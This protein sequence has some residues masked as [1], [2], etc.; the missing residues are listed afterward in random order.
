MMKRLRGFS[1]IL[2]L[3]AGA[4][5]LTAATMISPALAGEAPPVVASIAPV[6]SLLAGVMKGAGT[7]RLLMKG[8]GSPHAYALKPSDARALAKARAV[9]WIGPALEGFL[10]KPLMGLTRTVFT[11]E[12]AGAEGVVT[13]R[14]GSGKEPDPHIWLDPANAA[15]MVKTMVI[16]LA[17]IDP[18]NAVLY[19][20]NGSGLLAGL[21]A[22]DGEIRQV[23]APVKDKAFMVYHDAYG[24]FERRFGLKG[25]GAVSVHPGRPP[26]ARRLKALRRR[27]G[28]RAVRCVFTEPQFQPALARTLI[29]GTKARL[30]VLDL[31]GVGV[32]AGLEPGPGLYGALMRGLARSFAGCLGGKRG[33][34]SGGGG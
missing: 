14:S 29:E 31:L 4:G 33:G 11:V 16:V 24:H 20:R 22:L 6:H 9:F 12:L 17:N 23:L 18:A 19:R 15:Q 21:A 2:A 10:V 5:G 13:R 28:E 30:G 26:G 32:G 27:I 7:P 1:A 8:G 25:A 34:K 3:L